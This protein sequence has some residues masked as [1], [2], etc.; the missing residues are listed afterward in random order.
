MIQLR[1]LPDYSTIQR[2]NGLF[3]SGP[4]IKYLT[5]VLQTSKH[6][7]G[8]WPTI[9]Q[10]TLI[11]CINITMIG[12]LTAEQPWLFWGNERIDN[13]YY[14]RPQILDFQIHC[15]LATILMATDHIYGKKHI[16]WQKHTDERSPSCEATLIISE[17]QEV[18]CTILG[19][20]MLVAISTSM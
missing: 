1:S 17:Q 3:D 11:A 16:N 15:C 20:I 5:I 9:V 13:K 18:R 12:N 2:G 19:P 8:S 6:F 4:Q 14:S 7:Y 10:I